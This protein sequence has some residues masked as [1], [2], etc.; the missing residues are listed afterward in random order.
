MSGPNE[1]E[2][3]WEEPVK[4]NGILRSYQLMRRQINKCDELVYKSVLE[5]IYVLLNPV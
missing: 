2:L 1:V 4:P 5:F 3:S